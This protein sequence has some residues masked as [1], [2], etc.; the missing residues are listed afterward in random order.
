MIKGRRADGLSCSRW[1]ILQHQ[2][3]YVL[4]SSFSSFF[5]GWGGIMSASRKWCSNLP[6]V[7]WT[8]HQPAYIIS[9]CRELARWWLWSLKSVESFFSKFFQNWSQVFWMLLFCVYGPFNFVTRSSSCFFFSRSSDLVNSFPSGHIARFVHKTDAEWKNLV[10]LNA[11]GN[12][13]IPWSHRTCDRRLFI[14]IY[15]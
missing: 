6:E 5:C 8:M 2:V 3:N 13:S 11:P 15:F 12:S 10:R 1:T 4:L 7:R 14:F 9:L